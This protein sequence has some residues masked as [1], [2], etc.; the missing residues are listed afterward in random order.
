MLSR[1]AIAWFVWKYIDGRGHKTF[2]EYLE[3]EMR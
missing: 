2:K 3:K 1:K